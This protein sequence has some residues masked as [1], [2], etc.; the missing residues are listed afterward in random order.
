MLLGTSSA[1]FMPVVDILL[2]KRFWSYF[3]TNYTIQE[4][5]C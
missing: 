4:F 3:S 1:I 5:L 2:W